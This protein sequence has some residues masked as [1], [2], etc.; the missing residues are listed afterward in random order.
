MTQKMSD[1]LL[2][3]P[4]NNS[5]CPVIMH[6]NFSLSGTAQILRMRSNYLIEKVRYLNANEHYRPDTIATR[7]ILGV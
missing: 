6:I 3:I 1:Q 5:G 4:V 7:I 2:W